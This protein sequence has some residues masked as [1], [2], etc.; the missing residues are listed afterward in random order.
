MVSRTFSHITTGTTASEA[1]A[2]S[3]EAGALA[4]FDR[5]PFSNVSVNFT[6]DTDNCVS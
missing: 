5:I 6:F 2:N 1:L 3:K 4:A